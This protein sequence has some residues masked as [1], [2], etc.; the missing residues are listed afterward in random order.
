MDDGKLTPEYLATLREISGFDISSEQIK[1]AIEKSQK[2]YLL[3]FPEPKK[4]WEDIGEY[5]EET[6][7]DSIILCHGSV[8]PDFTPYFGGGADYHD[9]GKGFYCIES[10]DSAK[11]WACQWWGSDIAYIFEYTINLRGLNILDLSK[12][13]M[14]Y[15]LALLAERRYESD[16]PKRRKER[17]LSFV[18]KYYT[19][20]TK[21]D[22][23]VGWR[24][25]DKYFN[26]LKN[27]LRGDM[28][29]GAT[30]KAFSLGELGLQIVVLS[31][32]AYRQLTFV[33]RHKIS[34]DNYKE[35]RSSY[36]N[37]INKAN[38]ILLELQDMDDGPYIEYYLEDG[39]YIEQ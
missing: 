36:H 19:D 29:V 32:E 14:L 21:Y 22:I 27:F 37:K 18:K 2:S 1:S 38:K 12:M 16:E 6:K 28:S 5:F 3:Y 31:E 26:F 33:K 15:S 13:D 11:E 17:R 9:Y 24:A 25:D 4:L 39:D 34:G 35:H 20:L 7:K 30:R 10:L 8:N 23:V